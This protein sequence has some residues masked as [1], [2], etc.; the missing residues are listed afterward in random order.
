MLGEG[1]HDQPAR[2]DCRGLVAWEWALRN[3]RPRRYLWPVAATNGG[4]EAHAETRTEEEA[5]LLTDMPTG[6]YTEGR[7]GDR[8]KKGGQAMR[9][10]VACEFSGT[11]RDVFAAKGHE[12]W[13]CD[14]LPSETE[15]NHIQ[16]DVL[17]L[18]DDEW[19]LVIAHPPCTYLTVAGNKYFNPEYRDRFPDRIQ[20]REEAIEFVRSFF[21]ARVPMMAIENPI[22]VLSTR[23]G[24]PTQIVQP[25]QFGHPDRKPTCLWLRGLP[26]LAP[27][28]IVEPNIKTNRNGKTASCHHDEAL[29]LT[30]DERWKARSRTYKG[31]AAAM[32]EQWGTR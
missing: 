14:L 11:V 5:C 29:R 32:A 13:S 2:A 8:E 18:L 31:I 25:Y 19:D 10:L 4:K 22:G 30:P 16:G 28:Q 17:E 6:E 7:R 3:P 9:V 23:I 21:A 1:D 15:G 20:Q 12:A 24:K 27:T 26:K